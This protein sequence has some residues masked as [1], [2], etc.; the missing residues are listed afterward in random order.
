MDGGVRDAFDSAKTQ[1]EVHEQFILEWVCLHEVLKM[2]RADPACLQQYIN[3]VA[4]LR[5]RMEKRRDKL[6]E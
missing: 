4:T 6:N 2:R 5:Q 3:D 1:A